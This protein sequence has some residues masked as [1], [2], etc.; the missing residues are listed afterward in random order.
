MRPV[1]VLLAL[2]L[3]QCLAGLAVA[4]DEVFSGPQVG[5]KLPPFQVRSALG[6]EA[7]K[8]LDFVTAADGKPILL[9]FV[10][11]VSR[12]SIGLTRILTTFASSKKKDGLTTGVVWLSDDP[13]EAE[14]TLERIKHALAAET[15]TGIFVDG[16]EGPGSYG[17]NRKVALT[18]LVGN[19]HQV[20]A[21]FALVQPSLQVDLPK[22]VASIVKETGGPAPKLEELLG[23]RDSM[24][25]SADNEPD[26]NLR[27][28][29]R[30]V[31]RKT[32]TD[33]EVDQAVAK[34]E[35]Y[36]AD[37]E[38]ARIEVGRIT[39]TIIKAGKL[40]N[41]GTPRAQEHLERWATTYGA[42]LEKPTK[43]PDE[44][45]EP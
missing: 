41:Y 44:P 32:A 34:L 11:E 29:L 10:H 18:I 16:Q 9:V 22:I 19:E 31:I 24:Q 23:P 8:D 45:K 13:A 28:L 25:R 1:I 40:A 14:K 37:H 17:L 27:P 33:E 5:E 21:N 43:A 12:P 15:P 36:L 6:P 20:T 39:S 35:K 30:P 42:P 4:E 38:A 2:G 7:G 3:A 26:P